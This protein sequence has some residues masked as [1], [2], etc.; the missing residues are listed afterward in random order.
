MVKIISIIGARPQ[1]VKVKPIEDECKKRDLK[2]TLIH[3]GQHYN[4]KLSKV[5]FDE[6]DIPSPHYNLNVGSHPHG[7]Q[8]AIMLEGLEKILQKLKPD[9][10]IVYGDTNSTLAGALAAAKLNIPIAHVEA[11]LRSYNMEMPEEL[12]RV[13]TDR[14]S[15]IL[16][17]PTKTSVIDLKKEGMK[18][19]VYLVGDVMHDV[20]KKSQKFLHKRQILS[21]LGLHPKEYFLLTVH[22]Q[23]NTDNLGNLKSILM[24]LR[25]TGKPIIFPAHPRTKRA[26][27]K[28]KGFKKNQFKQ[29]RFIEPVGYIDMLFLEKNAE[30]ILTD[31]GGVQK[32][33]FWFGIPCITLRKETEWPETMENGLNVLAGASRTKIISLLNNFIPSNKMKSQSMFMSNSASKKIINIIYKFINTTSETQKKD[34]K[35]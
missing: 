29:F 13:L 9:M 14:L 19:G 10:V 8:T 11:G 2:H 26:L 27:S 25:E 20:F 35:I 33:A 7:K 3:T 32:E 16:F 31:S 17:C 1:F 30:K 4:H 6:L 22:R 28:I 23:E 24:A 18:K 34:G 12:N 5:F 21:K 15:S